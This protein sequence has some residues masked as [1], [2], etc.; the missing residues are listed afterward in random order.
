[1]SSFGWQV[2]DDRPGAAAGS[3]AIA[4]MVP[5]GPAPMHHG[6][7]RPGAI[8]ALARPACP[9]AKGSTIAPS[10]KLTLSG[11]LKV[12]AAGWTT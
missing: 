4:T 8:R 11:S 9:T 6:E 3:A 5:I 10:A 7:C 12:K 2:G 1:M